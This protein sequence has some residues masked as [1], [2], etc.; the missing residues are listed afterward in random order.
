MEGETHDQHAAHPTVRASPIGSRMRKHLSPTG[1][2]S[3][4]A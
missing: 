2:N 1:R 3:F 4:A